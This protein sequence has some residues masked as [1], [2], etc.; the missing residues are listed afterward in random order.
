L[1]KKEK[2]YN[3]LNR[4]GLPAP[5]DTSKNFCLKNSWWKG[6]TVNRDASPG[7]N[8]NTLDAVAN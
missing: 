7:D 4:S 2:Q 1:V 3:S 8:E 6:G 5:S